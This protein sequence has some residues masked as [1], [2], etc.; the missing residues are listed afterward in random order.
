MHS[1]DHAPPTC[2]VSPYG[3]LVD[4]TP[5]LRAAGEDVGSTRWRVG[6][7]TTLDWAGPAA[8]GYRQAL[9]DA[10][11]RAVAAGLLVDDAVM[12]ADRYLR[13]LDLEHE[14]AVV[15]ARSVG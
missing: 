1:T 4:P 14:Q 12:A 11:A 8:D 15:A 5:A 9:D 3:P 10:V 7:A 13:A 2:Q 6:A